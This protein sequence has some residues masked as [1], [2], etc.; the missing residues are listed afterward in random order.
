[1]RRTRKVLPPAVPETFVER[2]EVLARLSEVWARP[3]TTVVAGPGFGKSTVLAAWARGDHVAWYAVDADDSAPTRLLA[4]VAH[5][6]APLMPGVESVVADVRPRP[7]GPDAEDAER[8]ASFASRLA[9]VAQERLRRP[10]ALV[11]DDA[12]GLRPGS[13]SAR[14]VEELCRQ[15]PPGL[16]IVLSSRDEPPFLVS[17]MRGQGLLVEI[18]ADAL[19]LRVDDTRALLTQVVGPEGAALAE[20]VRKVTGGWAAAVRMAAEALAA[21]GTG[22]PGDILARLSRPGG[23]LF[24]YLVDEVL[25]ACPP[26]VRR[27]L[28]HAAALDRVTGPLCEELGLAH[29]SEDLAALARRGMFIEPPFGADDWYALTGLAREAITAALPLSRPRRRDLRRRAA[30]WCLARGH[31]EDGLRALRAADDPEAL[32]TLLVERGPDLIAA[33]A[34]SSVLQAVRGLPRDARRAVDELEGEALL[35]RGEWDTALACLERAATEVETLP[36]GLAWRIGLVHYLRGRTDAALVAFDRGRLDSPDRV[37]VAHLLAW[38]ATARWRISDLAVGRHLADRALQ[39]AAAAGDDSAMASAHTVLAMLASTEDDMAACDAHNWAGLAAAERVSDTLAVVRLLGNMGSHANDEGRHSD[40]LELLE[41]AVRL[42]DISGYSAFRVVALNNRGDAFRGLGRL[43]E[44][45]ADY[46]ASRQIC[47]QLGL[48]KACYPLSGLGEVHRLR[49]DDT[50]ARSSFEEAAALAREAG[51]LHGLVPALAGLARTLARSDPRTARAAVQELTGGAA[52]QAPPSLLAAGWVAL[53]DGDAAGAARL[54]DSAAASARRRRA[55]VQLAEALELNALA[56]PLPDVTLA[57]LHDAEAVWRDIDDPVGTLRTQLA[58]ATLRGAHDAAHD[59]RHRLRALGV[60]A[61]MVAA[62]G[63]APVAAAP[64][65]VEVRVLGPFQVR[66]QGEVVPLAAWRSRKARD[67]LRILVAKRGRPVPREELIE[68]LWPEEDPER[69]GQRLSVALSTLR[70]VLDPDRRFDADRFVRTADQAVS[71][72]LAQVVVDAERFLV[73][74]TAGLV[75]I[76]SDRVAAARLLAAADRAYAGDAF[77]DSPYEPWAGPL[78]D[79]VRAAHIALLRCL[80]IEA[81]QTDRIDAATRYCL[82]LL[83]RDRYDE[84][85][86]L[87]LVATH[88][89]AGRHGEARRHYQQYHELMTD[90]GVEPAAFPRPAL[91]S[92]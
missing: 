50:L 29:A 64:A 12:Q 38:H 10:T 18:G 35:V 34:A 76:D 9:E 13:P 89:A 84:D 56:A 83:E 14:L 69:T 77:E 30:A 19:A 62:A 70:R 61:G 48:R 22:D 55:R 60:D 85:A 23:V 20:A 37:A 39:V 4:G 67:L 28:S 43:E 44:A 52:G 68:A 66:R 11:L 91:R 41:R 73:D 87:L 47:A 71:L 8:A 82:R 42:A 78:R 7:H 2:P 24:A 3:L 21:A 49:G 5:A 32:R 90:L 25:A 75:A 57:R 15:A 74:V 26:R 40:G 17:R 59:A 54:A 65:A 80:A 58:A 45:V 79:E 31:L 86:H 72:D 6:L 81:S 33:G 36:P 27:L 53:A 46:A 63:P 16:H 51:D 1:M 92:A 88:V